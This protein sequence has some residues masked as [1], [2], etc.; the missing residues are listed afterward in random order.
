M[1]NMQTVTIRPMQTVTIEQLVAQRAPAERLKFYKRLAS[2]ICPECGEVDNF[3]VSN[4][5]KA[6]R[7]CG[8]VL[9]AIL[10]PTASFTQEKNGLFFTCT[11]EFKRRSATSPNVIRNSKAA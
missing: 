5:E 8:L 3:A 7:S 11:D 10:S 9:D 6:C 4:G 2:T 1:R